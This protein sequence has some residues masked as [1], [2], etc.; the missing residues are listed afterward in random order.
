MPNDI[1][2]SM[3]RNASTKQTRNQAP[4]RTAADSLSQTAERK[5]QAEHNGARSGQQACAKQDSAES[6][7]DRI[8]MSAEPVG[9]LKSGADHVEHARPD[10][11]IGQPWVSYEARVNTSSGTVP[12]VRLGTSTD[13]RTAAKPSTIKIRIATVMPTSQGVRR[14]EEPSADVGWESN[15][16][17]VHV[18]QAFLLGPDLDVLPCWCQSPGHSVA[19]LV[20]STG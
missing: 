15:V 14:L 3:A 13:S 7:V 20:P 4:N 16:R 11:Q 9:E 5:E 2:D 1:V 10:V 12:A 18:D 8:V 6:P 17:S 19:I